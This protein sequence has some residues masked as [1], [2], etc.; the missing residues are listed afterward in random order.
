MNDRHIGSKEE[1][2]NFKNDSHNNSFDEKD[3]GI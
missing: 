3:L 1:E 2:Q